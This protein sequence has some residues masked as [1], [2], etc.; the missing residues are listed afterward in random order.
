[1]IPD[2]FIN[3]YRFEKLSPTRCA[4]EIEKNTMFICI[5]KQIHTIKNKNNNIPVY[6][7]IWDNETFI[8]FQLKRKY[9]MIEEN[10]INE[11]K[12]DIKKVIMEG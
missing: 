6:K 10:C 1:M 5:C 11:N 4:L 7:V 2:Y 3:V 8:V 12:I 9:Y